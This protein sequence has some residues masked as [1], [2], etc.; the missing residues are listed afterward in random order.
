MRTIIIF[1]GAILGISFNSFAQIQGDIIDPKEKGVPNAIII[2]I[3]SVKNTADTVKADHRGFYD[4]KNL[5]P[6]K[7]KIQIKA[8]G[9]KLTVIEN[10]VVKEGDVGAIIGEPDLYSG[11]RLDITLTPLKKP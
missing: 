5:K 11:Q 1:L 4:F 10:I 6:G 9:F 3:D 8:S 7:Y 2:A